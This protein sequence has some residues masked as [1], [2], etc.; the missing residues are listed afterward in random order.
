MIVPFLNWACPLDNQAMYCAGKTLKCEQNHTYDFARQGY[1]NLLPAQYK[2]SSAPGDNNIM[3]QARRDFLNT[4]LY[5][6][7]VDAVVA[8]IA[9]RMKTVR[10]YNLVDA[11]C[12][13]GY[14]TI[15]ITDKLAALYP[16]INLSVMGFDISK[17][18]IYAAAKR[19]KMRDWAVATNSHIPVQSW[20]ADCVLSLFGFPVVSEFLR[21]LKPR[22]LLI[23]ADA[24]SRHLIELRQ[25]VYDTVMS[26]SASRTQLNQDKLCLIDE[27]RITYTISNL[28]FEIVDAL[29]KMTPHFYRMPADKYERFKVNFPRH[30]TVDVALRLYEQSC[31]K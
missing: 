16:E 29:L 22:G 4:G 13:E 1:V 9:S 20:S 10:D 18:C 31:F 25:C 12:G 24:A 15:H 3:V 14:Y 26:K 23:T 27:K 5:E 21:I 28:S 19:N 8:C 2:H 11:G 17:S 30:I 7:I 6:E